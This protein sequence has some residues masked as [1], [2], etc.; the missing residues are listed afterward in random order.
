MTGIG[1]DIL[2]IAVTD[3]AVLMER[4]DHLNSADGETLFNVPVMGIM[5]VRNG[6]AYEWRDYFDTV[7]WS[8]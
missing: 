3:Y 1:T 2:S 7:P 6:L 5:K 8:T 4:I